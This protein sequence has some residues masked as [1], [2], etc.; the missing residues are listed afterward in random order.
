MHRSFFALL[1]SAAVLL[2]GCGALRNIEQWKCDHLGMC[3]FGTTPSLSFPRPWESDVYSPVPVYGETGD[4]IISS[5]L[6][7]D[8]SMHPHLEDGQPCEHCRK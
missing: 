6:P 3:H 7:V 4:A 1:S 2:T 5:P 8:P